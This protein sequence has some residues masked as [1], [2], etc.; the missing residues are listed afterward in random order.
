MK[1]TLIAVMLATVC[2]SCSNDDNYTLED[3]YNEEA[4]DKDDEQILISD[5]VDVTIAFQDAA[6][7]VTGQEDSV[8]VSTDG[9]HVTVNSTLESRIMRLT[10][11][12]ETSNGSLLV[13]SN[14][15]YIVVL[16]DAHITNPA[17]PAINNQCS[18]SLYIVS[19]DGTDNGLTDGAAYG[20]VDIKQKGALYSRGQ[21][22]FEGSGMLNVTGYY[23]HA[24]VSDDYITIED[25]N[26]NILAVTEAEG[27]SALKANDG[28]FVQAGNITL[29]AN[30]TAS[31]GIRSEADVE[32]Y[33]GN[34]EIKT[35]GD[36][37]V[38]DIVEGTEVLKDTTSAA[39]I[40]TD[41]HFLM[42]AGKLD[43]QSS[44]DG[45]KGINS[46]DSV[47]VN[48]GSLTIATTG[49][50]KLGKPKGVKSDKAIVMSGGTLKVTVQKS[51]A[52]DNG[53]ESDDP[54]K[55]IT[56]IGEPKSHSL[57]LT[58]KSVYIEF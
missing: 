48:G 16:N 30:A 58:Q 19:A 25:E 32:I 47:V 51:W 21:I 15:K 18:K 27:G 26:V 10:L 37:L 4:S 12:G 34:I 8:Q 53:D 22:Y 43:I 28:V 55:R 49:N 42:E 31:R 20:E 38:E 39:G 23:K 54:E 33:G 11:S 17:G 3:F 52:L 9:G 50:N 6:A 36:C 5:T 46:A 57:S 35:K 56:I 41:G 2:F 14:V 45:G 24:I 29:Q 7:T 40:K 44:G 1:K 13:Y